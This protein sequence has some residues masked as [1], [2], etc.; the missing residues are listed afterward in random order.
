MTQ[1]EGIVISMRYKLGWVYVVWVSMQGMRDR[2]RYGSKKV[3][4]GVGVG[5]RVG[6]WHGLG[7]CKDVSWEGRGYG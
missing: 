1:M 7:L 2:A 4:Q 6:L 5:C 3:Y